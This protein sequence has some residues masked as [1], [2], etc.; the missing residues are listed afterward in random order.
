MNSNA[1][2]AEAMMEA[3]DRRE[4][5]PQNP[6]RQVQVQNQYKQ[7]APIQVQYK[8][9]TFRHNPTSRWAQQVQERSR[10]QEAA[11]EAATTGAA[12]TVHPH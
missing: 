3:G 6:A 12:R 1:D 10:E 11:E 2:S 9:P 8:T 5:A 7:Q 4:Q